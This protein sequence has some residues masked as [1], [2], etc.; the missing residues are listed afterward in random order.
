MSEGLFIAA[1]HWGRGNLSGTNGQL[2][3][4]CSLEECGS[5]KSWLNK[6]SHGQGL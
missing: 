2:Y 6:G 3:K 5:Q 4:G 1:F